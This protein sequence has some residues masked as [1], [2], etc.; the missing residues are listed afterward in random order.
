[1]ES[2]QLWLSSMLDIDNFFMVQE[3]TWLNCWMP[4]LQQKKIVYVLL[5]CSIQGWDWSERFW[6]SLLMGYMWILQR[7]FLDI[8]SSTFLAQR[9]KTIHMWELLLVR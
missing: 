2:D 9:S 3:C 5:V 1:M 6:R 4:N 8:W 7:N